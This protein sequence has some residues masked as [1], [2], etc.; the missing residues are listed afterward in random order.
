MRASREL[1]GLP[2][3]TA[4]PLT[5]A[6]TSCAAFRS[7]FDG[8]IATNGASPLFFVTLKQ[9]W[10]TAR[11]LSL[12][13]P[14]LRDPSLPARLAPDLPR[15]RALC[16]LL[17]AT[18]SRRGRLCA[19]RARQNRVANQHGHPAQDS[20]PVTRAPSTRTC[21]RYPR[22]PSSAIYSD[23][24]IVALASQVVSE[25]RVDGRYRLRGRHHDVGQGRCHTQS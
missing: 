19:R 8:A 10:L 6:S 25:A 22:S 5:A 15:R 9:P 17:A 18:L 23:C 14:L 11:S 24:M 12:L 3:P 16:L 1:C 7:G 13:C 4:Q 21:V 2:R 20:L